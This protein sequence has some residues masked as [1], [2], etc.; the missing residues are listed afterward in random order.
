MCQVCRESIVNTAIEMF[1]SERSK[2]VEQ[3]KEYMSTS[4]EHKCLN[5]EELR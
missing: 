5:L 4:N 1:S 2:A 3:F